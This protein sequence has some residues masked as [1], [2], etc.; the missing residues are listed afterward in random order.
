[1]DLFYFILF[2]FI[3]GLTLAAAFSFIHTYYYVDRSKLEDDQEAYE[4]SVN[5]GKAFVH[6]SEVDDFAKQ[7]RRMRKHLEKEFQRKIKK[8]IIVAVHNEDGSV[9]GYIPRAEAREKGI[10]HG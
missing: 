1:M 4:T 10:L 7:P 6:G 5:V 2:I 9:L 3:G 8:G